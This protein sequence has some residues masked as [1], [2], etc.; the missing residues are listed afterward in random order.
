M[1]FCCLL[2][3]VVR[4]R[5]CI[6]FSVS[7]LVVKVVWKNG[8]GTET[9]VTGLDTGIG[10]LSLFFSTLYYFFSFSFFMFLSHYAHFAGDVAAHMLC[11]CLYACYQLTLAQ[12]SPLPATL[13]LHQFFCAELETTS[14]SLSSSELPC[15]NRLHLGL[16]LGLQW[17]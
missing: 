7:G 6:P 1:A 12:H 4:S 11:G 8:T 14:R 2:Q 16:H 15:F 13:F 3:I 5:Y 9:V 10:I 17:M